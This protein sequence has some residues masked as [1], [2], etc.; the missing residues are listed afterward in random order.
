MTS[1]FKL[2]SN[3]E[4]NLGWDC[5]NEARRLGCQYFNEGGSFYKSSF[6]A[7]TINSFFWWLFESFNCY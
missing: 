5:S 3:L 7:R 2:R 4:R 1:F 6:Y